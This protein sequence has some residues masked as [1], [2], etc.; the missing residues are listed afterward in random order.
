MQGILNKRKTNWKLAPFPFHVIFFVYRH[1]FKI[2]AKQL[3]LPA[4][5]VYWLESKLKLDGIATFVKESLGTA[6]QKKHIP[7]QKNLTT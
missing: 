7:R 3:P 4:R 6:N 5:R 1:K 2:D